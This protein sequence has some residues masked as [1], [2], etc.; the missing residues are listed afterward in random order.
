MDGRKKAK[1]RR[2]ELTAHSAPGWLRINKVDP[3]L[4]ATGFDRIEEFF[5]R[6]GGSQQPRPEVARWEDVMIEKEMPA[7]AS[8][9]DL[10]CGDGTLLRRLM[11]AKKVHG[12][13]VENDP[14][15]IG[16]CVE[17][18]VPVFQIDLDEGLRRLPDDQY[19]YVVLEETLQTLKRPVE[20]LREMLRVGKR[21]VVSFP[22]FGYWRV[23]LD[24]LVRGRMP[25][26][27]WLPYQWH[28]T[29]N[30]HIFTLQDFFDWAEEEGVRIVKGYVLREGV[31]DLLDTEGD[32]F[33]AEEILLIVER[34]GAE[35]VPSPR[36]KS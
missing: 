17:K 29:P 28:D 22:N 12:Q 25:K 4:L 20:I 21:G 5:E 16:L 6:L 14:T 36:R 2:G 23:R 26:T 1:R 32:N 8:V 33:H 27:E 19:D 30:I 15:N 24:L 10:G 7:H 3:A 34:A 35:D 11:D 13:G 9:L 31:V 18:G